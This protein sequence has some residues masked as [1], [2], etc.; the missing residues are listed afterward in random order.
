MRGPVGHR[1]SPMMGRTVGSTALV[2]VCLLPVGCASSEPGSEASSPAP[3]VATRSTTASTSSEPTTSADE[4]P[5][6]GTY[7]RR[8]AGVV[9]SPPAHPDA[10]EWAI[11]FG[12]ASSQSGVLEIYYLGRKSGTVWGRA[13]KYSSDT[14]TVR[15]GTATRPKDVD[16]QLGGFECPRDGQATYRWSR[17]N[18]NYT[19]RL[20]A[21]TEPCSARRVILE[22]EW[23]FY[24]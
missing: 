9:Q 13:Y 1:T 12:N 11:D 10:D 3:S 7:L 17:F 15:L 20:Q 6:Y 21:I 2:V 24:D 19:L 16:L 22:G 4:L 18:R 14:E 23:A 8:V 5:L